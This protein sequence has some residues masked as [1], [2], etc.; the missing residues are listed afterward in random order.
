ME[1]II[2]TP[3]GVCS[4]QMEICIEGDTI[5]TVKIVGGCAGNT[6]GVSRLLEGMKIDD[7]IAR[8]EGIR[9]GF[10]PTSCPDQI[11]TAL[12]EYKAK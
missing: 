10:K 8:L 2:Y 12:K 3:K 11:A 4:R 6:Q 5:A 1:K 7:A 9:C